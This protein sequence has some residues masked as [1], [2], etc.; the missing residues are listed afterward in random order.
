MRSL[1]LGLGEAEES[2]VL[3]ERRV[4]ATEAGVAGA[5]DA[6][7]GVI[8]DELGGGVVGVE[9][10]LVD[11]WNDLVTKSGQQRPLTKLQFFYFAANLS[12]VGM[13]VTYLCRR[14]VE[15]LLQVLNTKVGNAN[16]LYFAS[17]DQLLHLLPCLDEVP[18]WQMLLEVGRIGRARPVHEVQI[19]VICSERLEGRVNSLLDSLVPWVIELGGQPDLLTGDAGVLDSQSDLGFVAIGQLRSLATGCRNGGIAQLTAVSM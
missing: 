7:G 6:L 13:R 18:V 1:A 16:V 14:I 9:F 2:L 15:Q 17:A 19:N 4:G 10:D 8:C 11:C 3:V 5:V 12:D